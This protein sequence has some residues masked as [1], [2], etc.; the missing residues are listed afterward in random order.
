MKRLILTLGLLLVSAALLGTSTFAWFSMNKD[1]DITGM[2]VKAT[3]PAYIYISSDPNMSGR[4][5][6][7]AA[8]STVTT[9]VPTSTMDLAH[10]F[11]GT[12]ATADASTINGKG[13]V[14]KTSE[15]VNVAQTYY[16]QSPNN[17]VQNL[18]VENITITYTDKDPSAINPAL[19][20]AVKCKDVTLFFA[21]LST[22]NSGTAVKAA[23][24][25]ADT[26]D[27]ITFV[28]SGSTDTSAKTTNVTYNTKAEGAGN[29]SVIIANM[30]ADTIYA[31]QVFVFFDGEDAAC[32]S[33]NAVKL[34]TL[35]VTIGFQAD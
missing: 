34:N 3:T 2:Q 15:T 5:N 20:I 17:A 13:Y 32:T 22:K 4:S 23:G 8:P 16:V 21:P 29:S 25:G 11:V 1:V 24:T 18:K 31:V 27:T 28:K 14:A 19:R 12:A 6:S 35:N 33:N 26:T 9:V 10:W 30:A 7:V